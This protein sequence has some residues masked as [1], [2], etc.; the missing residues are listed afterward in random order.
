MV[1]VA[2]NRSD[3]YADVL[4]HAHEVLKLEDRP[5]K[6]LCIFELNGSLVPATEGWTLEKYLRK[7]HTS[8]EKT[9]ICVGSV[10]IEVVP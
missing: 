1:D 4:R 7:C 10:P 8:P 5:D 6:V 2:V 3:T 9:K